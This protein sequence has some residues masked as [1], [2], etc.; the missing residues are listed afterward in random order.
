MYFIYKNL[1]DDK[2]PL[3][4]TNETNNIVS[5]VNEIPNSTAVYTCKMFLFTQLKYFKYII[6]YLFTLVDFSPC[7]MSLRTII[8]YI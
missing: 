4:I 5:K 2:V 8:K 3:C 7:H 6:I 1:I